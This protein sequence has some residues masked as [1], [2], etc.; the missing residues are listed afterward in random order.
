VNDVQAVC[1]VREA[2]VFDA[3]DVDHY[4]IPSLHLLI[5][6][7]N[8]GLDNFM[9]EIQAAAE[10]YTAKYHAA[11]KEMVRIAAELEDSQEDLGRFNTIHREYEKDLK[12]TE[13]RQTISEEV[14]STVEAELIFIEQER[15]ML[16]VR[17]DKLKDKLKPAK[18]QFKDEKKKTENSKAFGQPLRAKS[19]EIHK[20]RG[21]DRAAQFG[22][23][24]EGNGIQKLMAEAVSIIDDIEEQ[25]L[26]MER[27]AGTDEEIANMCE[28]HR[29]LFIC[30]DGY[31]SGLRTKRFHLTDAIAKK[32]KEFLVRSVLLERYLGMSITPKTHAMDDHSI[33]QLVATHGFADLGEDAGER[34][35]QDEAKA[36]RRL[37]AI[38]DYALKEAFKSKDEVKRKNPKVHF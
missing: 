17:V 21:I 16:Q 13:R 19:D 29:Q 23:D 24:L 25:L 12:L 38:H 5:G 14:R 35:H 3:I 22:G 34:N 32:T 11:E 8:D 7:G 18:Q 15:N 30:W 20:K 28:K 4:I 31:F 10:T 6:K 9:S 27:V 33:Q 1:G 37:G 2:P 26:G 36:D